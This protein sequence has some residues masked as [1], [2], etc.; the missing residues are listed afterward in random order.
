[1]LQHICCYSSSGL[2]VPFL[3]HALCLLGSQPKSSITQAQQQPWLPQHIQLQA[4]LQDAEQQVWRGYAAASCNVMQTRHAHTAAARQM[5]RPSDT[6]SSSSSSSRC[7]VS[8]GRSHNPMF[9][10]PGSHTAAAATAAES[11]DDSKTDEDAHKD[12]TAPT[13]LREPQ[14]WY[15]AARAMAPRSLTAHL[16][17]TN[18]GKTHAAIAALAAAPSGVYCG[19]LRL[20][21]CEV[22]RVCSAGWCGERLRCGRC[23]SVPHRHWNILQHAW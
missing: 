22:R 4:Q 5:D 17:P 15:A 1:M 11:V 14:Q 23:T 7:R 13:D 19:P 20:L 9:R 10:Q 2:P 6:T 16:G 3:W 18:S 8:A 21:A 12:A